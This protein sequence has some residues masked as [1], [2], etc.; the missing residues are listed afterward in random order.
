MTNILVFIIKFLVV[1][2]ETILMLCAIVLAPV[3][4]VINLYYHI[5][6]GDE[7]ESV[8]MGTI[9][10]IRTLFGYCKEIVHTK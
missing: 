7:M 4:F 10:V 3:Q 2:V 8:V 9:D 5:R 6:Y 1:M